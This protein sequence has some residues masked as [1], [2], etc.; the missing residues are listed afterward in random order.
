MDRM[1]FMVLIDQNSLVEINFS[2]QG[3]YKRLS[4]LFSILVHSFSPTS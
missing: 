4:V 2:L 1:I 3:H